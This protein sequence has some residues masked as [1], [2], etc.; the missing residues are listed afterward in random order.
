MNARLTPRH[1]ID[2]VNGGE[3]P[4]SVETLDIPPSMERIRENL[5]AD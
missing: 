2:V 1:P 5:A 4:S 3:N